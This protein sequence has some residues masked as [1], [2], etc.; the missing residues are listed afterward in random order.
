MLKLSSKKSASH[1]N[2]IIKRPKHPWDL[3]AEQTKTK[4]NETSEMAHRTENPLSKISQVIA[5]PP[6]LNQEQDLESDLHI[7]D[8]SVSPDEG[9][10]PCPFCTCW[11]THKKDLNSHV[12]KWCDRARSNLIFITQSK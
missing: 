8:G 7:K 6:D 10:F 12:K 2:F 4:H 5:A 3:V 1:L 9:F 11:F